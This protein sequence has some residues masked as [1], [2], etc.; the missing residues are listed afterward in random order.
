METSLDA[1]QESTEHP[2]P[3]TGEQY[4][5]HVNETSAV[6]MSFDDDNMQLMSEVQVKINETS[7]KST[8]HN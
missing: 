3:W 2:A 5:T 7:F 1:A 8:L 4:N 6:I